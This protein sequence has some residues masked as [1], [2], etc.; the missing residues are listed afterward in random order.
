M[1]K[2][3]ILLCL[4]LFSVVIFGQEC[5]TDEP[6]VDYT[7]VLA[8]DSIPGCLSGIVFSTGEDIDNNSDCSSGNLIAISGL[9]IEQNQA[10]F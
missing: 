1:K 4:L 7:T 10:I 6:C 5:P 8:L 9:C 2:L 3:Q